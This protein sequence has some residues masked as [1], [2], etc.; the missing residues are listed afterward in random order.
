VFHLIPAATSVSV[1]AATGRPREIRTDGQRLAITSL[2][3]VRDETLAYPL[4]SGPRTVF[5]VRAAERRFRLVHQLDD[6][7]WII[8]D[9]GRGPALASAA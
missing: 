9:L 8:E 2:E 7:R 3:S 5:V 4:E 6:R 1:D